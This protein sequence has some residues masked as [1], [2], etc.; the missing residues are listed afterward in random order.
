ML[1]PFIITRTSGAAGALSSVPRYAQVLSSVPR[2]AQVGYN[3]VFSSLRKAF[4]RFLVSMRLTL[5]N[6]TNIEECD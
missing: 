1:P 6:V 5:K 2:Y 4:S 3:M